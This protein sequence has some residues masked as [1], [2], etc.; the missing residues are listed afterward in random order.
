MVKRTRSSY[1]KRARGG[2]RRGGASYYERARAAADKLKTAARDP[3][4]QKAAQKRFMSAMSA[5]G[6]QTKKLGKE[7]K[8]LANDP[9]KQRELVGQA[10]LLGKDV[11][12]MAKSAAVDLKDKEKRAALA[13]RAEETAK[14][15]NTVAQAKLGQIQNAV[16]Q[17]TQGGGK[18]SRRK[19]KK[20]KSKRRRRSCRRR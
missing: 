3:N 13:L 6:E 7:T 20:S 9:D 17:A 11:Y 16:A 19:N 15:L 8:R 12:G 18:K 2:T 14:K 10:R 4:N 5:V 1:A